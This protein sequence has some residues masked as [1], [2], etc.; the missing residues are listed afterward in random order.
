MHWPDSQQISYIIL[1]N[2]VTC[3]LKT[4]L[5]S[6]IMVVTKE[7]GIFIQEKGL[8]FYRKGY[9]RSGKRHECIGCQSAV[10]GRRVYSGCELFKFLVF[11]CVLKLSECDLK[12][13][14][15]ATVVLYLFLEMNF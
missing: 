6:R 12:L 10:E 15:L 7:N 14:E 5:V 3:L 13:Q 11:Y 2:Q 1:R 8:L 4:A 9:D